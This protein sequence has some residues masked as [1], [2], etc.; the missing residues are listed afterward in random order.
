M[1]LLLDIGNSR[2]RWATLEGGIFHE[3]GATTHRTANLDTLFRECWIDLA[4]PERVLAAVVAPGAVSDS[5]TKWVTAHWGIAVELASSASEGGG[6]KNGYHRPEQ[7][8]VDRWCA[9]IGARKMASGLV[10]VVDSG[11]AI[12]IDVLLANGEH[13][14]G[15]IGPGLEMMQR[16][17]LTGTHG[18]RFVFGEQAA[19]SDAFGRDTAGGVVAGI[20]HMQAG[21]VRQALTRMEA[22]YGQNAQCIVT[23]GNAPELMPLLPPVCR[24]EPVLVLRGLAELALAG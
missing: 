19:E 1:I 24:H 6:V 14:G 11:T 13:A 22:L 12:T 17:L 21:L 16:Q 7:L 4:V 9:L 15:W 18:V 10:C 5:L 8:G 2:L 3:G 23:G 20:R